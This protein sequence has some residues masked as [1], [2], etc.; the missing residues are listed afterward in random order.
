MFRE[1]TGYEKKR[2]D[3]RIDGMPAS[4]MQIVQAH[5][6]REETGYMRDYIL[7]DKGD[8]KELWFDSINSNR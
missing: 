4:P 8:I 1:L 7:N 6:V 3:L 2:V 5:V